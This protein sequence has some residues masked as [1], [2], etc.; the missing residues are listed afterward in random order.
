MRRLRVVLGLLAVLAI[1]LSFPAQAQQTSAE[2]DV[3]KLLH[4]FLNKVDDPAMHDRFW[5]DDL[6]YT[7]GKGV[8]RSKADIMKSMREST[9]KPGQSSDEGRSTYEAQDITTHVYPRM[10]VLNFRLVQHLHKQGQ[11]EETHTFR[12]TGIFLQRDGKWQV[13]AWQATPEQKQQPEE[14]NKK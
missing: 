1:F 2:K 3:I 10:V 9:S 14:Q 13:V 11:P 4:E 7:S 5:A 6:I 12:N 8:K